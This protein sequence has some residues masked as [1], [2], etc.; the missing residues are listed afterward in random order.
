MG[1]YSSTRNRLTRECA[2]LHLSGTV[3][4]EEPVEIEQYQY[5]LLQSKTQELQSLIRIPYMLQS[6]DEGL[7]DELL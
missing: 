1:D 4:A 7:A 5:P 6:F 2:T 3:V